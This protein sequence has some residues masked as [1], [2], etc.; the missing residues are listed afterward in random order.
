MMEL[1]LSLIDA[2]KSHNEQLV[3]NE[4]LS[5]QL[6][7]MQVGSTCSLWCCRDCFTC[8]QLALNSSANNTDN[9]V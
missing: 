7:E 1:E 8:A 3:V 6:Q 2:K 5:A 9:T 4:E